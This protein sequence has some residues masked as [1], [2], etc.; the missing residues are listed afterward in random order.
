MISFEGL[1][2]FSK[3]A[4]LLVLGFLLAGGLLAHVGAV[5]GNDVGSAIVVV[6]E[7]RDACACRFDNVFF[8]STPP[9]T[10]VTVSPAFSA[11]STKSASRSD[12]CGT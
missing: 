11:I 1:N 12:F 10:F 3:K 6:I 2:F 5:R 9:K 4:F 8:V 7:N